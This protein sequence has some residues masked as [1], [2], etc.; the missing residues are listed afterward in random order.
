MTSCK[1]KSNPLTLTL[2]T[3]TNAPTNTHP[4]TPFP[5]PITSLNS[6]QGQINPMMAAM[7]GVGVGMNMG[8]L[9]VGGLGV[10]GLGGVAGGGMGPMGGAMIGGMTLGTP[11]VSLT[12]QVFD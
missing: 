10:G 6:V 11:F 8:G 2:K 5:H 9:G 7:S 12:A 1:G 3:T 4:L